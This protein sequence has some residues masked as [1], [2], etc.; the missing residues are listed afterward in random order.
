MVPRSDGTTDKH[1]AAQMAVTMVDMT[2]HMSVDRTAGLKVRAWAEHSVDC[3]VVETVV[4]MV[5]QKVV[6]M[7]SSKVV[8]MGHHWVDLSEKRLAVQKATPMV[9]RMAVPRAMQ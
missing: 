4:L 9:K 5:E 6:L 1:L 2:A 3:S 7:G 8:L